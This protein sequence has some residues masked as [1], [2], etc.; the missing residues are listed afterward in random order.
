MYQW[1]NYSTDPMAKMIAHK[2]FR[3]MKPKTLFNLL[4]KLP[5]DIAVLAIANADEADPTKKW[6]KQ[7]PT[8][9]QAS[10]AL[11]AAFKFDE[12]SEGKEF[13]EH[14]HAKQL[15]REKGDLCISPN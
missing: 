4:M 5:V 12:T 13:W 9:Q 15:E 8:V 2:G 6:R 14:V 11:A 1:K 3:P 7:V 10:F